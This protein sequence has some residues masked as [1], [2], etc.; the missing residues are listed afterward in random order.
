MKVFV[1]SDPGSEAQLEGLD[2]MWVIL[3]GLCF[4]VELTMNIIIV[5]ASTSTT[6]STCRCASPASSAPASAS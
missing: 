4:G 6:S 3:Y 2:R 5:V 1:G